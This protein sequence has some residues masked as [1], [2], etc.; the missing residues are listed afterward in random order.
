V[1]QQYKKRVIKWRCAHSDNYACVD[2]MSGRNKRI[3]EDG[4]ERRSNGAMK[5]KA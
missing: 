1:R 2:Q 3:D 4:V 5:E